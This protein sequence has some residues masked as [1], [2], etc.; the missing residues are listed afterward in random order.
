MCGSMTDTQWVW[1]APT[2]GT[3]WCNC[4]RDPITNEP[5]HQVTQ[6]VVVKNV[7]EELGEL[8]ETMTN[9]QISSV[10]CR[11]WGLDAIKE[12]EA[13]ALMNSVGAVNGGVAD[14]YPLD[15]ALAVIGHFSRTYVAPAK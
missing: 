11:L 10:T 1:S 6:P 8:P 15:V 12:T 4:G 14:E 2:V 7:V 9:Q 5:K 13:V 3:P